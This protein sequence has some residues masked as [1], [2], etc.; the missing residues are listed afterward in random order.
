MKKVRRAAEHYAIRN[1]NSENEKTK[2][3]YSKKAVFLLPPAL[4][5]SQNVDEIAGNVWVKGGDIEDIM[6]LCGILSS[7]EVVDKAI[8]ALRNFLPGI[9]A[10]KFCLQVSKNYN[11]F[12]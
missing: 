3:A 9:L 1:N 7:T 11:I 4:Q 10:G 2:F 6:M 8:N 12:F 5:I